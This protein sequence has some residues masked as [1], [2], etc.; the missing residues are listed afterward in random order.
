MSTPTIREH[1]TQTMNWLLRAVCCTL[2][3][4]WSAVVARR[5]LDEMDKV[6]WSIS[7]S[8]L[9]VPAD[10][11]CKG[12]VLRPVREA[13]SDRLWKDLVTPISQAAAR[14][15]GLAKRN[16]DQIHQ[17][18]RARM[19]RERERESTMGRH[20]YLLLKQGKC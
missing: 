1:D 6:S 18:E 2:R 7:G 9:A 3:L 4:G 8:C 11:C 5:I 13:E 15:P 14:G 19:G 16:T 17:W 12:G 20:G 10:G